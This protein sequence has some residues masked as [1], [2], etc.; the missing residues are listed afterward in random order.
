MPI[1]RQETRKTHVESW[2]I[3]G[4]IRYEIL[5]YSFD[6]SLNS[7]PT[8]NIMLA[9]GVKSG[10]T[11]PAPI[12]ALRS[13]LQMRTPIQVWI[14]LSTISGG[15]QD[16]SKMELG[17]VIIFDGYTAGGIGD[18]YTFGQY[19]ISIGVISKL[20]DLHIGNIASSSLYANAPDNFFRYATS[21]LTDSGG[22]MDVLISHVGGFVTRMTKGLWPAISDS[23]GMIASGAGATL[24]SQVRF[25]HS[26]KDVIKGL[27]LFKDSVLKL[28]LSNSTFLD[29]RIAECLKRSLFAIFKGQ[30][31]WDKIIQAANMFMFAISPR[32]NSAKAIPY[33]P[34]HKKVWRPVYVDEHFSG[35]NRTFAPRQMGGLILLDPQLS[36]RLTDGHDQTPPDLSYQIGVSSDELRSANEVKGVVLV[37][38]APSWLVGE[39][40]ACI[41]TI[42]S[43]KDIPVAIRPKPKKSGKKAEKTPEESAIVNTLA[44]KLAK[45]WFYD[46]Q[47]KP[48]VGWLESRFRLDICP[49]SSIQI[50]RPNPSGNDT[51]FASVYGV[52]LLMNRRPASVST[53]F[54]FSHLRTFA[55]KSD[56]LPRH[57]LY[58]DEWYG[59]KLTD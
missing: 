49:G 48:R 26:N 50:E 29:V 28:D 52:E 25:V 20:A 14:N 45:A 5:S 23:L 18:Q 57:P 17:R 53:R 31:A 41:N 4:G 42:P 16:T 37:R 46:E 22:S 36:G 9:T 51:L 10:T 47:Y 38:T 27:A 21:N 56:S 7:I 2:A 54:K 44:N 13:T 12:H 1:T 59:G 24:K 15:N 11:I 33:C 8:G 34:Q 55:E 58:T 43:V 6:Y 30:T 40:G 35:S 39:G 3:I 32:I 19:T